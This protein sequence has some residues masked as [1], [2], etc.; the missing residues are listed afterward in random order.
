MMHFASDGWKLDYRIG[1]NEG[2]SRDPQGASGVQ[3]GGTRRPSSRGLQGMEEGRRGGRGL[4][5]DS[6][7]LRS[8]G[9]AGQHEI[10][11]GG[12]RYSFHVYASVT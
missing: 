3:D 2:S 4:R 11:R 12:T 8:S 5:F 6:A 10:V 1:Q 9:R 7:S